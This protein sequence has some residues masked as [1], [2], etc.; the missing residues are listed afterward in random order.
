M[1]PTPIY[2]TANLGLPVGQTTDD[3]GFVREVYVDDG[4]QPATDILQANLVSSEWSDGLHRPSL[5]IDVSHEYRPSSTPGHAHL[6]LH[7]PLTWR[8]YRRLLKAL[9]KAGIIEPGYYRASLRR[10]ATFLR[11]P[12]VRK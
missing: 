3:Y 7:T 10:K 2:Y 9:F 6:I 11:P 5:D 1:N 4:R 12:W 8:Q